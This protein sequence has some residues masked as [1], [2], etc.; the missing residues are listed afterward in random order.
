MA[1]AREIECL[2]EVSAGVRAVALLLA[3]RAKGVE[4]VGQFRRRRTVEFNRLLQ[5]AAAK[6]LRVRGT[7]PRFQI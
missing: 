3:R 6:N 2:F 4:E 1:V 7:L 5:G